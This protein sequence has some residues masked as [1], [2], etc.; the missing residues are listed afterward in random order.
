MP[1]LP[2]TR[3]TTISIALLLF[4]ALP[5]ARAGENPADIAFFETK[6]RPL[7][8]R[9]CFEC[10]GSTKQRGDL[11]LDSKEFLAQGGAS[12][13]PTVVPKHPE[14]SNLLKAVRHEKG[15]PAM[16]PMKKLKDAE[17]ADL[18]RWIE[19]GAVYPKGVTTAS[20]GSTHWAF[21]PI[22]EPK[23]PVTKRA[24]WARSPIDR[25]ILAEL[26]AHGLE[27]ALP[28]DRRTLIRRATFD[29]IGLPPTPEEVEAFVRDASSGA[30][31]K[32]IDRL[33][34]SPHYG[35]RWGRHWLD[36]ARYADSNGM[37]ENLVYANAWR[38]RDYVIRAFNQDM[39]Y[40][41]FLREQLAGDLLPRPA[42]AATGFLVV[43]PKMLAEDDPV[44][45]EMDI[46]DEQ[47]ETIGRAFLGMT[48]GCARCHDHKN[49][50]V[51]MAD[52]Y[53]LAGVFKS[54]QAMDNFSVVARWHERS[55]A[56]KEEEERGRPAQ[57]R[58]ARLRKQIDDVDRRAK[59][60]PLDVAA[61]TLLEVLRQQATKLQK[62]TP[63]LPATMAVA[64]KQ[65]VNL[66]IHLRG[67][68]LTLGKEVPRGFP[69]SIGPASPLPT[70]A[71]QS[72]R[73][74]LAEWMV[75]PE[76]P[77]TSRVLVNRLWHWHFG[78]GLVRTPDNFGLLGEKPTHPQLL[79]WLAVQFVKSGW[80]IKAMH[81]QIMLSST[82]Q[83][84]VALDEAAARLDP[85]NRLCWTRNCR[86]LEAEAI[87]D[88]LLAVSGALDPAMGGSLLDGKNRAYVPGYP[89]GVYDKYEFP[90]RSVY[91]PVLRSMLYDVFQ[92]FDFA[93]PSVGNGQRATTTVAPQALFMM[94]SKLVQDASRRL[95]ERVL[96][97]PG[98]PE[99][100]QAVYLRLYGRPASEREVAQVRDYLSRLRHSAG[101]AA[102]WQS[103]C[104]VLMS[105]NEFVYVE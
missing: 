68:H 55:V 53:S 54:T 59:K 5:H 11:R 41:Q 96:T 25:F 4:A 24:G 28:A 20:V 2:M 21:Q 3:R 34:A 16:P 15:V 17:I 43:G 14:K 40:D 90:R 81:R 64:D 6:V 91:L 22:V 97:L 38:Y 98:E 47:I 18:V 31:E 62:E 58:L 51:S 89:N 39:P 83:M 32:L 57:D 70:D 80:S 95:A 77:L 84:S 27:P 49:D 33:L 99:R 69:K 46:I 61:T 10:H 66:K 86:R 87:R 35:E 9:H 12:G 79:D 7:L 92:A 56:T 45:M 73:R 101:E 23:L 103:V 36:L 50:P 76:H 19:Q 29:L 52:Y 1:R 102:A 78:A 85:D 44:K 82:Y 8:A 74:E 100:I 105:A 13:N 67:N 63:D 42:L 75:R 93:D 30:Y 37:D 94:N 60:Q 48:F 65:P 104:R 88:S 72:G 26:E 71:K